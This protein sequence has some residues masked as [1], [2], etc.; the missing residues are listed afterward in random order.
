MWSRFDAIRGHARPIEVLQR[1]IRS[2]R[3]HHANLLTGPDGVG[4]RRV[5]FAAAALVNCESPSNDEPC[6]TC[7]SCTKLRAASHPDVEVIAPDGRWIK[8][9]QVRT[10]ASKTRF[11]PYEG[12]RRVFIIDGAEWM[13]EEAANA[14]LKT[15][16]EPGGDTIFFV[17][18][19]QPHRLLSTIRSRCQPLR[20]GPLDDA[21][22]EALVVSDEVDATAAARAARMGR[23]SVSRAR[24]ALES[25]VFA[26]SDEWLQRLAHTAG[27]GPMAALDLADAIG[28]DRDEMYDVLDWLRTVWR[29][30]ALRASG[31][32]PARLVHGDGVERLGH[33]ARRA[34]R[35]LATDVGRID[36]AERA[37]LG[38][39]NATMVWENLLLDLLHAPR[40]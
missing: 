34:P 13:R 36:E 31:V 39:V 14:L 16:E 27:Q 15:L 35:D 8:I 24:K 9:E 29:D 11:R 22:V 21:D 7:R 26:A 6:G 19:A 32:D 30:L 5:A 28:R 33:V 37:L 3:L 18:S 2:D 20:F 25:P 4:K 17:I 23:G 12:R 40:A 1:A 38:N 10:I